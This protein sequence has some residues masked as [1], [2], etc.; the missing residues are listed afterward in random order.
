[1]KTIAKNRLAAFMPK[2]TQAKSYRL[3]NNFSGES[4]PNLSA[5]ADFALRMGANARIDPETC[6]GR[7]TYHSNHWVEFTY[8]GALS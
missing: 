3:D 5:M 4:V 7:I 2:I 1:M 6:T 8:D